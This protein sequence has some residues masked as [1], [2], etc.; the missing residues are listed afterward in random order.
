[1]SIAYVAVTV[2]TVVATGGI[3]IAAATRARFVLVFMDEVGVPESWVSRLG[4]LKVAGALGLLAGLAVQPLG[5][6]AGV[7]L[8]LYFVGAIVTHVRARVL[9]NIAFPGAYL[10]LSIASLVL[11]ITR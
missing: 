7:G 8:V 5:I 3:G 9:S 1:M 6:A 4:V 11:A 2:A 10:G